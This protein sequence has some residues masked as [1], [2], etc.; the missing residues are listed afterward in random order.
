LAFFRD[1]FRM[2]SW[3]LVGA[4]LQ[5][6]SFLLLGRLA[7]FLTGLLFAYH[8]GT[9]L[10]KDQGIIKTNSADNVRWGKWTARLPRADGITREQAPEGEQITVFVLGARSNHFRGRYAP[11]WLEMGGLLDDMWDDCAENQRT[12]GFLG[13][14]CALTATDEAYGNQMCWLSYWKDLDSLQAFANGPVHQKGFNWFHKIAIKKYP[15]VGIMHET[16]QVPKGQWEAISLN[17]RP[18]GIIATEQFAEDKETGE[19]KKAAALF[20]AKGKAWERMR[21]RMR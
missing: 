11:G 16:Y 19:M 9:G 10:L 6:G 12:N 8:L 20:P 7:L 4:C 3:L 17:I 2:E 15:G 1:D 21:D 14:T 13:R 18:F 5:A